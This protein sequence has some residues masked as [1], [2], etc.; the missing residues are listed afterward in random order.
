MVVNPRRNTLLAQPHFPVPVLHLVDPVPTEITSVILQLESSKKHACIGSSSSLVEPPF[1]C[2]RWNS[3]FAL[4][5]YHEPSS[6]SGYRSSSP[7]MSSRTSSACLLSSSCFDFVR[8]ANHD[9]C[10]QN[11]QFE[12]VDS[13]CSSTSDPQIV[14]PSLPPLIVC[15]ILLAYNFAK[16]SIT[17][18]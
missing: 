16:E 6:P 15:Q 1:P 14:S 17:G 10:H 4:P 18:R 2:R 5:R 11:H 8:A 12:K 7:D 9:H 13:H 3:S